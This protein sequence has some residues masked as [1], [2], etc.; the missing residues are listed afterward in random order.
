MRFERDDSLPVASPAPGAAGATDWEAATRCTPVPLRKSNERAL[1]RLG[2]SPMRFPSRAS[3]RRHSGARCETRRERPSMIQT[4]SPQGH[5]V[6]TT[7]PDGDRLHDI[8]SS[9]AATDVLLDVAVVRLTTPPALPCTWHD[10]RARRR[11]LG[12]PVAESQSDKRTGPTKH[13]ATINVGKLRPSRRPQ[14]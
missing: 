12:T 4:L 9:S 14:R 11:P 1:R 2:A 8:D 3:H 7:R 10:G 13:G 5:P 6:R